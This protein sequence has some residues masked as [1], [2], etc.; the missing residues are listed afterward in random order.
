MTP[1]VA[2]V[3]TAEVI[4]LAARAGRSRPARAL[5]S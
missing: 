4:A 5:S 1:L 3:P 2:A